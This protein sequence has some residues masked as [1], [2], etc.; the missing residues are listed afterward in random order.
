M[1]TNDEIVEYILRITHEIWEERQVEKIRDYYADDVVVRSPSGVTRGSQA[2]V[3]STYATLAE[4]PD[5]QLL[6][7]DVLTCAGESD[8][9]SSHR[10]FS[11][12]THA[13]TGYFGEPTGKSLRYR[14]IADCAIRDGVI[15]DEWL[16]RDFGAITR[17]LG[18]QPRD[19]ASQLVAAAGGSTREEDSRFVGAP[20]VYG[21]TGNDD[22]A[23][24][25]LARVAKSLTSGHLLGASEEIDRAAQID[26]PGGLTVVGRSSGATA[27][28]EFF[29]PFVWSDQ[30]I[31]HV[32]G[33]TDS[34]R[35]TRAAVRMTLRG[36]HARG[37][38]FGSPTDREVAL[39][40]I[41]HAEFSRA[42]ISRL[43]LLVDE[44]AIW[45]QVLSSS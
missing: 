12:A 26:L 45:R 39:L 19:F 6:G 29:S 22:P 8:Q 20:A 10:I 21:G 15:F 4:F 40:T 17:Q 25:V 33:C 2:V 34:A 7:E 14:V 28:T 13:G 16:V 37:G 5:R 41:W 27:A 35:G 24:A 30:S 31:D 43:F 44:V 9:F 18:I 42:G 3:D 32:L 11:T 38:M 36:R 23:G 1:K